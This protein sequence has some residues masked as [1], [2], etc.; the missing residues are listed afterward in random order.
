MKEKILAKIDIMREED[1]NNLGKFLAI[2]K[3]KSLEANPQLIAKAQD[4]LRKIKKRP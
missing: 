4:L 1:I 2:M 3:K